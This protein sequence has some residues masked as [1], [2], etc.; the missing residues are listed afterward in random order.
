MA[1]YVFSP[2]EPFEP[3]QSQEARQRIKDGKQPLEKHLKLR[4]VPIRLTITFS[5]DERIYIASGFKIKPKDWDFKESQMKKQSLG[6]SKFNERLISLKNEIID[7]IDEV[8]KND[9]YTTKELTLMIRNYLKAK[10]SPIKEDQIKRPLNM[11]ESYIEDKKTDGVTYRT[12]QKLNT[13]KKSLKEFQEKH[14]KEGLTFNMVDENFFKKYKRYLQ[15]EVKNPRTGK[16]GYLNDTTAKFIENLKNYLKW[17]SV[18]GYYTGNVH[19]NSKLNVKREKRLDIVVL[20]YDE[21][22][23]LKKYD[24]SDNPS[25][26]KVVDLFLFSCFTGAR[27][28]DIET[29]NKA[30]IEETKGSYDWKFRSF[31]TK[32][33]QIIPLTGYASG[34]IDILKKYDFE[35]PKISAQK[36]NFYIKKACEKA[37]L[38][39]PVR[40]T[41]YQDRTEIVKENP[42]H[43]FVSAHT[44]RRTCVS[45]LL[46]TYKMPIAMVR[47]ITQH[48]DIKTLMKYLKDDEEALRQALDDSE[49]QRKE[50]EEKEDE[51]EKLK[52][53]LEALR[54]Q[55]QMHIASK[56]KGA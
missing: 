40:L 9:D 41:R 24:F 52:K 20:N 54:N 45:I 14:Y 47:Q 16:K 3:G 49:R 48:S 53:E 7:F 39:R 27:W 2:R 56:Q 42:L 4:E 26:D 25:Y 5:K 32:K 43:Q 28:S 35:L 50:K 36:F 18:K 33:L 44:G 23:L 8:Q 17:C 30:Q 55:K 12:I 37:E 29:F 22:E 34:A 10:H 46:N 1:S 38:N 19:E 15:Y 31:K 51:I 6:S 21:V 11:F 13:C